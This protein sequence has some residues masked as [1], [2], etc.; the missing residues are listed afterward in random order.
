MTVKKEFSA[1]DAAPIVLNAKTDPNSQNAYPVIATS[2]GA[3]LISAGLDI[4]VYDYIAL[5]YSGSNVST[6]KYYV[7]GVSGTLVATLTLSYSG[8]NVTSVART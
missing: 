6:V 1:V 4:P 8:S 2:S 5:T 3:L 7:G